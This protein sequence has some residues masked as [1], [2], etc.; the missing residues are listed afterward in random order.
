MSFVTLFARQIHHFSDLE[1]LETFS[2]NNIV[3]K[4]LES[5]RI[6]YFLRVLSRLENMRILRYKE[7]A[8]LETK[9]MELK[10]PLG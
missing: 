1:I 2:I 10:F 4:K 8:I 6:K 9:D 3:E 5:G 7:R